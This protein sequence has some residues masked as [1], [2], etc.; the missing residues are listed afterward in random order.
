MLIDSNAYI[1]H[2]PFRYRRFNTCEAL[3]DERMEKFGVDVSVI[4]NLDG[5][6]Y[7]NTQKA[8]EDLYHEINSDERFK[9]RFIPFAIINPIYNGWEDDMEVCM[10]QYGMK[11]IRLYPK[12]HGYDLENPN[13]IE[14]VK[15]AR[16]HGMPVAFTLR[17]VDS[18]P[19][20]WHDIEE[21]WSLA[22]VI[23][24]IKE[25]PDAKFMILNVANSTNLNKEE[26]EIL[27]KADVVLDTS[28]RGMNSLVKLIETY[29]HDKFVFGTHS[30]MLDYCTGLL[31]IESLYEEEAD[32]KAKEKMLS[33]NIMSY[34]GI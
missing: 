16:D 24:I 21:E 3:L 1:G 4:S 9:D 2:W 32:Q 8:N 19:S 13:C 23:P 17:M 27:Q 33:Q 29:G 34:L 20:S 25:V 26:S 30:P 18:R 12:Y 11:G 7:K 15:R 22:D 6:Y 5:I 28:G 14:L 31:R 10:N